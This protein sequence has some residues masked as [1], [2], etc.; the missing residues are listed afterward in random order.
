MSHEALHAPRE[1]L[2]KETLALHQAIVSSIE[3][4]EA[5]GW[6]R[7][8]IGDC[9]DGE[10]K[11]I[12]HHSVRREIAHAMMVLEWNRRNDAGFKRNNQ[13]MVSRVGP[14]GH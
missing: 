3:E 1:R 12:R 11:E 7:K 5:G 6:Y 8:W 14:I 13:A 2:S 10:M 9:K 4:R